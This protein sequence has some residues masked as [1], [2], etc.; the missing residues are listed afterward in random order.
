VEVMLRLIFRGVLK[1]VVMLEQML[2][3]VPVLV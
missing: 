1:L 2:A 3:L